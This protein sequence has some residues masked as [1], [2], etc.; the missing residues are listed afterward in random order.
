MLASPAPPTSDDGRQVGEL[1]VV[2]VQPGLCSTGYIELTYDPGADFF[3]GSPEAD[4]VEFYGD[5]YRREVP[6]GFHGD[7]WATARQGYYIPGEYRGWHFDIAAREKWIDGH[8]WERLAYGQRAGQVF[9]VL[10][11]T[12]TRVRSGSRSTFVR[13]F[14]IC[15]DDGGWDRYWLVFNRTDGGW[16]LADITDPVT[17]TES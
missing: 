14:L 10:G 16:R 15:R 12:G 4:A 7:V 13:N 2:A 6:E 5:T 17:P 9:R 8:G 11:G 1:H 3:L